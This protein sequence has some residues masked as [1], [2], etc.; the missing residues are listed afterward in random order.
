[1]RFVFKRSRPNR[2]MLG[3]L[4]ERIENRPVG[5]GVPGLRAE[6]RNFL[7]QGTSAAGVEMGGDFVQ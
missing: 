4:A 3:S 1:M 2:N 6:T 7:E 5:A